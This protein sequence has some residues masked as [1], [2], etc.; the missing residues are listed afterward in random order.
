M[1]LID[2]P[3]YFCFGT[4][5]PE[6]LA[7]DQLAALDTSCL[8]LLRNTR[9]PQFSALLPFIRNGSEVDYMMT[10]MTQYHCHKCGTGF[11]TEEELAQHNY[12]EDLRG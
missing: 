8:I 3:A 4:E 2:R 6:V 12:N 9:T 1:L 10:S 7:T 5:W 11:D